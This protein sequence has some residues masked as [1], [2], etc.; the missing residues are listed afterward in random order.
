VAINDPLYDQRRIGRIPP[1]RPVNPPRGY[2]TATTLTNQTS[3]ATSLTFSAPFGETMTQERKPS[4]K[5]VTQENSPLKDLPADA[6]K[7][8]TDQ[9]LTAQ[10]LDTNSRREF[11]RDL[12][13][14]APPHIA[15]VTVALQIPVPAGQL[16]D[17]RGLKQLTAKGHEDLFNAIEQKLRL[18]SGWALDL[19]RF[20]TQTIP[21]T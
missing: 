18:P 2:F 14:P 17:E 3:A 11:I 4:R 19:Q 6:K 7:F 15:Y 8:L 10:L 12:G 21:V 16:R 9:I 1:P 20:R 13:L 5:R